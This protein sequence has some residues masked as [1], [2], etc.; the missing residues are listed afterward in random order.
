MKKIIKIVLIVLIIALLV[1]GAYFAYDKFIKKEDK[2]S[3][4][5]VTKEIKNYD[6]VLK[7]DATKEYK[8]LFNQLVSELNN[9]EIDEEKYAKLIAEMFV[10]DFY[11][12][13]DKKSKNDIGGVEFIYSPSQNNFVLEASDTM[14]K[15]IEHNLYDNRTQKLPEVATVTIDEITT[16]I[17]KYNNLTDEKAYSL[18]ISITYKE[19][20]GYPTSITMIIGHEEKVLKEQTET[21]EAKK[22]TKLAIVSFK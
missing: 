21:E 19:D 18:K 22:L 17:Q 9:K 4:S 8:K 13:N 6:Y 5:K 14:Y 7:D 11:T 10:R 3:G 16:G 12:L 15:Y 1:V 2:A 20:L